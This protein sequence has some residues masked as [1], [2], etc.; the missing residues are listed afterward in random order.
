MDRELL[1]A[2]L[3]VSICVPLFFIGGA[4]AAREPGPSPGALG[5]SSHWAALWR[6]A[7]LPA[8]ASAALV[9]WALREPE[10]AESLRGG[11]LLAIIPFGFI[12]ARAALRAV[13]SL[14]RARTRTPAPASTVGIL[15]P[16]VLV[17]E[18]FMER[19]DEDER[20]AVLAHERAHARSH[21]P[22]RI[23]LAQIVTDL[24]WPLSGAA[25]R[26]TT[27]R[28]ALELARDDDAR[29]DGAD[30]PALAR[31]IVIGA[32]L[33]RGGGSVAAAPLTSGAALRLR[34]ERLLQP[35]VR[36]SAPP[37]A[38]A[39]PVV[40]LLLIGTAVGGAYVGEELVSAIVEETS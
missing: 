8:L 31:A 18:C 19:L 29:R 15:R 22:L 1:L 11:H 20:F 27:W 39:A 23:W 7:L 25:R 21:D 26:Y 12:V 16:R 4:W 14:V 37:R 2:A 3:W 24:Q 35:Q 36:P 32:R 40:V 6:P 9:G 34:V 30:G 13:L 10:R 33:A 17:D 5:E 38:R 28:E